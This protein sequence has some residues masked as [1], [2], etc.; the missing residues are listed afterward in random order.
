[1]HNVSD[2][3]KG[4]FHLLTKYNDICAKFDEK[5]RYRLIY[6]SQFPLWPWILLS[7]IHARTILCQNLLKSLTLI[8]NKMSKIQIG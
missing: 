3:I 2:K 1:M 5:L 8:L 4:N 7:C 6:M